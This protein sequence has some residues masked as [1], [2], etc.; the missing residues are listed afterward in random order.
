MK[1]GAGYEVQ[2]IG[3]TQDGCGICFVDG[4]KV[5][6][7]GA[8][9][10][11]KVQVQITKICEEY[12]AARIISMVTAGVQ[13][14]EPFCS[15]FGECG[16]CAFQNIAYKDQL[17]I[18]TEMV[19]E[20]LVRI[21]ELDDHKVENT[22]GMELPLRYRNKALY[23]IGETASTTAIGFYR[24]RSNQV[25]DIVECGIQQETGNKVKDVVK[26]HIKSHGLPIYHKERGQGLVRHLVTRT[27]RKTGEVM[28]VLVINGDILPAAEQFVAALVQT[29]PQVKSIYININKDAGNHVMGFENQLIY[30]QPAIT[31]TI[32]KFLFDISPLS[33]FQVNPIQTEVVYD[34]VVEYA[35]LTGRETV[36]D[37]YC[38]IGTISLYLAE[39]ARRV[40]GVEA[41]EEAIEDAVRNAKRNGVENVE[42]ISGRVEQR[43]EQV[44]A[45]AG[46]V[47]VVVID[48]PRKGCKISVLNAVSR[49]NPDRIVYVSCNPTTLARDVKLLMEKGFS[50]ETVQPIDMFPHTAHV[51]TCVMLCRTDS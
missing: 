30:G 28:V 39:K 50:L 5:F 14:V 48:P 3:M 40:I 21:A 16:G 12:A 25:V 46:K 42:F 38:G 51:E 6:V 41:V 11:E 17:K 32:G 26:K 9:L 29:I 36:L 31:D 44:L 13:R 20:A 49:L 35:G 47:D 22:I 24:T 8:V 18:K 23:P 34:K 1:I 37:L 33:F 19:R 7:M 45:Q 43:M 10:G 15:H 2:I 27:S 4:V